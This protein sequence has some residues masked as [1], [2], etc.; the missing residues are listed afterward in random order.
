MYWR[1]LDIWSHHQARHRGGR[2]PGQC[3]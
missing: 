3:G 1:V 2:V